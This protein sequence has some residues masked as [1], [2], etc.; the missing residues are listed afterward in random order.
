MIERYNVNVGDWEDCGIGLQE[1]VKRDKSH[2]F[3]FNEAGEVKLP[4][5]T[6]VS[7]NDYGDKLMLC[8]FDNI[9]Y[10]VPNMYYISIL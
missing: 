2:L 8:V 3:L 1:E 10:P 6:P 9:I 4:T 5:S 7:T